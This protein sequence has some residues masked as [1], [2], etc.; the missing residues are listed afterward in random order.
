MTKWKP[1]SEWWKGLQGGAWKLQKWNPVLMERAIFGQITFSNSCSLGKIPSKK[2]LILVIFKN[3]WFKNKANGQLWPLCQEKSEAIGHLWGRLGVLVQRGNAVI[4]GNM[5]E[6][7]FSSI[8]HPLG[9]WPKLYLCI[10]FVFRSDTQDHCFH[11][12]RQLLKEHRGQLGL[13]IAAMKL[14]QTVSVALT[15]SA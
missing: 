13:K 9:L 4:L 14:A 8:N 15:T 10:C 12:L 6:V 7:C 11:N 3:C 1:I 5:S 2:V